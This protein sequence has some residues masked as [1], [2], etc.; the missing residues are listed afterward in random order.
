EHPR[1][2][3]AEAWVDHPERV[4]RYVRSDELHSAFNFDFLLAPWEPE[5]LRTS[6]A[7][8][9]RAHDAVGAAPTWVLSNHD[10]VR[11]VSR[12]ARPQ[13]VRRLRRLADVIDLP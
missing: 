4:A 8:A 10:T 3:I 5:A 13:D 7:S 11:E 6:I 9:L 1:V 2:L 12:Y